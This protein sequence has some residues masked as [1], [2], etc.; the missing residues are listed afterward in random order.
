MGATFRIVVGTTESVG[1]DLLVL[2]SHRHGHLAE[3]V[4]GSVAAQCLRTASCPVL[5]LP[6]AEPHRPAAEP[7]EV[8]ATGVPVGLL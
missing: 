4:F 1:A 6:D 5:V 2:G 8:P 7:A 3:Q